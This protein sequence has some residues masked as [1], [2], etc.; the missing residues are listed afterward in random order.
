MKLHED[1]GD[2][3]TLI[4]LTA[5]YM[6]LPETAIK[7]D[8]YIVKLM[9][10]LEK[11]EYVNCVIFKGGTSLSKCY[12]DS[13]S[14]F[15]EDIDLSYS[16]QKEL[17]DKQYERD[18]KAIEKAITGGAH[19]E[20]ITHERTSRNKSSNVWFEN[21]DKENSK[22]KLEI[23]SSVRPDPYSIKA[24]KSYI[25]QYLQERNLDDAINEY[26]LIEV[27]VNTLNI[28][29]T[30]LDKVFSVKRHAICGSLSGKVRH[31][32]DVTK[33]YQMD[34]IQNYLLDKISLKA[35][36]QTTKETDAFYLEKRNIDKE[37]DPM[38]KYSFEK[39]EICFDESIRDNYEKL[40]E[41]LLYTDEKQNF[42][43]A[44]TIFKEI[45]QIFDELQ[46]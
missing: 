25:H 34:E 45:S 1:K 29:R 28:E 27:K 7:R 30:F 18:L 11:S 23:G 41:T 31:I 44:V 12:P 46:E 3:N 17:T 39:W 22:V 37:Y 14:R 21:D 15:S 6:R 35:L 33:L 16:P 9:Q 38:Q 2:F 40:H 10:N 5:Q 8:Y 26:K 4:T 19:F 20:Q 43:D 32:Y 24:M 42:D 36:I 13:I